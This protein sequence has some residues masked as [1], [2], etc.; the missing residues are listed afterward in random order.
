MIQ[1]HATEL[2]Q[3]PD[4]LVSGFSPE[5]LNNSLDGHRLDNGLVRLKTENSDKPTRCIIY[6]TVMS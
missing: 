2:Y 5:T 4:E 6:G 1:P 3:P